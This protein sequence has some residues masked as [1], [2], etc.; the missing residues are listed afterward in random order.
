MRGIRKLD[1][2]LYMQRK[3][4]RVWDGDSGGNLSQTPVFLTVTPETLSK[5]RHTAPVNLQRISPILAQDDSGYAHSSDASFVFI[6]RFVCVL[7]LVS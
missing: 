1:I 2:T 6:N 4:L 3:L 7:E 5:L